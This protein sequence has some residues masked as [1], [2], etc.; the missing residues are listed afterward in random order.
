MLLFTVMLLVS[1]FTRGELVF[2]RAYLYS[3]AAQ[4]EASFVTEPFELKGRTSNVELVVKTDL[5]NES[6]YFSFALINEATGQAYD[7]GREVSYYFGRDSDGSWSE[8]RPQET[9]IIPSVPP[10]RY[11]LRVEPEME[12]QGATP[13]FKDRRVN[14]RIQVRRDV[15][16]NAFFW[17]TA[18]LLLAPPVFTTLRS[19]GFESKRWKESD[20]S[21][22]SGDAED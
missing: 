19:V 16:N 21:G 14:Y 8:G 13:G 17:I 4:G 3:N 15:P 20:Y 9:V 2:D 22:G 18:L 7:F 6:A 1:L 12:P 10:G 5:R 11:Y